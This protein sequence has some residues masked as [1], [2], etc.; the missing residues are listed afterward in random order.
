VSA[1]NPTWGNRLAPVTIVE[2]A[3][4]ECP[5]SLRVE[6]TLASLRESYGPDKL[7]IVWKNNPLPFHANARPAAE[8]A[9]GVF[10]LSGRD[11][12]WKFHDLAFQNQKGLKRDAYLRW[13]QEAG[14]QDPSSYAAALDNHLWASSIDEDLRQSRTL[15][16]QGTPT[17]YINGV[18]I[19]GAQPLET[20]TNAIDKQ[21]AEAQAQLA[22]GMPPGLLYIKL[23]G[24]NWAASAAERKH[25]EEKEEADN[26]R[27]IFRIPVGKAPVLGPPSALV[28]IVEFADFQC[29][30]SARVQPTLR[31][32]RTKYGDKLR[33]VWHNEPLP[34]HIAAEGAAEA[35]LEVR[36]EKGDG[37]FWAMH[38]TLFGSQKE[39]L[40]N[41]E[42]NVDAM[43]EF[44]RAAGANPARVKAAITGKT[45][46]ADIQADQ[47]L[48][49]DYQATGTPHF[50]INGRRFVGAQPQEKFEKII[51]EEI[52]KAQALLAKGVKP[53]D[54]YAA[55]TKDGLG[56]AELEKKDVPALP[57]GDPQLGD[58][59]AR[60]TVHEWADFQCPFC[61]R[62]EP[63][64][65][66]IVKEYGSR[67]RL[68]WHDLPL[69]FHP[70]AK[71]AAEAAR[72]AY[73]QKGSKGF[74]A[75]HDMLLANREHLKRS[76][77]DGYATQLNLDPV[78]FAAALDGDAHA[79]E[80]EGDEK[81]AAD[82][83]ISGT[84]TFVIVSGNAKRGYVVSGAQGFPKFRKVIE[85]ALEGR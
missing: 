54:L 27:T 61:V 18:Y 49:D 84:P 41:D 74:W 13:A 66:Q 8:A 24:Q 71:L 57:S 23:A 31:A 30:F 22:A 35:A 11:A 4:L 73:A 21:L 16:V 62:V 26:E 44:A 81:A 55:L 42:P 60:V 46:K 83:G 47:D 36:A 12:F 78:R 64:L 76:D 39:L 28:T 29:P 15:G 63:T 70:D 82:A 40:L 17:F 45:H 79:R 9:M 7:R 77:L 68:V 65:Q 14:V 19:N 56:P 50:F 1:R 34:F 37:A 75:M 59:N 80:I 85:R 48:V 5:Y 20:F 58:A 52:A 6:A 67:V 2:F 3:D 38:D 51:D 32:L 33:I 25:E 43:A 53:S 72:E 10:A 69:A